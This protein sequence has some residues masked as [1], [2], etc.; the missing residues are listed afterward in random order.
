MGRASSSLGASSGRRSDSRTVADRF[1]VHQPALF[2]QGF[3]LWLALAA[4]LVAL[5]PAI[6]R[7]FCRLPSSAA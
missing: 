5:L 1:G 2:W 7:R 6:I 3:L 4:L